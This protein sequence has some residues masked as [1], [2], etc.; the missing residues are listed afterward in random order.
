MLFMI[1]NTQNY[2]MHGIVA[3]KIQNTQQVA[4]LFKGHFG[5]WIK[6]FTHNPSVMEISL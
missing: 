5:C 4:W 2:K 6:L 1:L 3:K